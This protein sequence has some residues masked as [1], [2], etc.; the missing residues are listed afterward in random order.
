MKID[1]DF[2]SKKY[3]ILIGEDLLDEAFSFC[4]SYSSIAIITDSN[5]EKLYKEL[6]LKKFPRKV[7]FFSF[8]A[9]E[10]SKTRKTKEKIE[11]FL[12]Q[13]K[14]GRD[15]I[16]VAIGGGI[17]LD[18][19]AFTASTYMRGIDLLLVPTTFLAMVDAAIGGKTAINTSYGKNLIGTFY[20]PEKVIVDSSFLKTLTLNQMREGMAEVVKM[21]AA[22]DE[23]FFKEIEENLS[24][25][26]KRDPL[27]IQR[28]IQKS[29]ELKLSI[30]EKDE[31]EASL[32]EILNF[33]H[34]F[35]HALEKAT[36]YKLSHGRAVT[37][38]MMAEGFFSVKKKIL[39]EESFQ[40]LVLL[41]V[42][43]SL[44]SKF[45][46]EL[47]L[48]TFLQALAYDKKGKHGQCRVL[49]LEKI[50]KIYASYSHH[51]EDSLR[52]ILSNP[53]ISK[54]CRPL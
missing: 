42:Q 28:C 51:G 7:S 18:I 39:S 35:G 54:L 46:K 14:V 25:W 10:K 9:G 1:A 36:D 52:K 34:T 47:S 3:S 4:K 6:I 22:M 37:L 19:A 33:G 43:Y 31:K 29:I 12:F 40:R 50:G 48:D 13:S 41:L 11:D 23:A 17:V 15:G 32:R 16:I 5:V 30:V 8:P 26:I 44:I 24:L 38:G 49:L 53:K 21:A 45:P 27:F 2:P 20:H